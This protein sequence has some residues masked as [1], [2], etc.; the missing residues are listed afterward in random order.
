MRSIESLTVRNT[1]ICGIVLAFSIID[2]H[3]QE[4]SVFSCAED[5][6][7]GAK[8][9]GIETAAVK[10]VNAVLGDT[11]SDAFSLLSNAA[12]AESTSEQFDKVKAVVRRFEP[13]NVSIQHPFR[14]TGPR[15]LLPSGLPKNLVRHYV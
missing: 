14:T 15:W 13:K 6:H 7:I 8:R 9:E 4:P 2:V 10:F 11:S 5:E 1:L 12:Q 3:A